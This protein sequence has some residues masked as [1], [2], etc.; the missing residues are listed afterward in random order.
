MRDD[1][2]V[3]APPEPR[4]SLYGG[5]VR[6]A[7]ALLALVAMLSLY[8]HFAFRD[9]GLCDDAAHSVSNAPSP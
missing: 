8:K 9:C 6:I 5:F 2:D 1:K 7:L 3:S 4:V